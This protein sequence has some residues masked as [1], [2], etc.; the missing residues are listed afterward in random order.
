M[1]EE[2]IAQNALFKFDLRAMLALQQTQN[3]YVMHDAY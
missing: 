3:R 1:V 2:G